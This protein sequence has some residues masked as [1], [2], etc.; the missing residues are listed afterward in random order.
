MIAEEV[1]KAVAPIYQQFDEIRK[2]NKD[3][4]EEEP[5]EKETPETEDTPEEE[6]TPEVPEAR[7]KRV[8]TE[9]EKQD[10]AIVTMLSVVLALLVTLIVIVVGLK[11][12]VLVLNELDHNF[13][14]Q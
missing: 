12:Y 2:G 13:Y 3:H 7:G 14:L 11:F 8:R 1:S 5:E 6:G 10:R 4:N 9:A